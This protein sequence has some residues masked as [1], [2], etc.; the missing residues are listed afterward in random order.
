MYFK[1][2]DTSSGESRWCLPLW[3]RTNFDADADD[4]ASA[5]ERSPLLRDDSEANRR[6]DT[7]TGDDAPTSFVH[8]AR[9]V[10]VDAAPLVL[11]F[12][13]QYSVDIASIVAVGRLG[14]TELGAVA[15]T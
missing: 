12:L 4:L 13:L 14:T 7:G 9:V 3:F 2:K 6:Q 8:E 5:V 10:F 11:T 15:C 1:V